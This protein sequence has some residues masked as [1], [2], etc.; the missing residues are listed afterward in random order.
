MGD[1]VIRNLVAR[2]D[3]VVGQLI[4]FGSEKNFPQI[5]HDLDI[6]KLE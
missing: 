3:I 2:E 1:I 6:E 4:L 5:S